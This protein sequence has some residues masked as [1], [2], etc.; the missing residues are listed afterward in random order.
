MPITSTY[1]TIN[2]QDPNLARKCSVHDSLGGGTYVGNS[3]SGEFCEFHC[4]LLPPI[5]LP[6][7][8]QIGSGHIILWSIKT[9]DAADVDGGLR[10]ANI[11]MHP[12]L[13]LHSLTQSLSELDFWIQE[14]EVLTNSTSCISTTCCQPVG[15]LFNSVQRLPLFPN[16]ILGGRLL[17]PRRLLS[18]AGSFILLRRNPH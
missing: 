6:G 18:E 16:S 4:N 11:K 2:L 13:H 3:E 1:L 17:V 10:T 7:L 8:V 14:V 12:P 9:L 15:H 5:S